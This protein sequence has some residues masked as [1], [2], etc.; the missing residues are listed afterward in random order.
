MEVTIGL[1]LIAGFVSFISPCVLPLVPAYIGYM[2]GRL[3]NQAAA[4]FRSGQSG[5]PK[6]LLQ[7]LTVFFHA[8]AFVAGFSL[9]FVSIGL[10]STAFVQQIGGI[11]IRLLTD[12]IGRLGGL[13][14]MVFGLHFM[15]IL[16]SIFRRLRANEGL[17]EQA[18]TPFMLGLGL[19]AIL[20]W[21]F[22]GHVDV[23]N[24][25]LWRSAPII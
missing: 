21:G 12:L 16:P 19:S 6:N 13:L 17:L 4:D 24:S 18:A 22:S 5:E 9:V 15:D 8:L 11:N 14:I 2:G 1:A 3:T 10:L 23:W 7:R 25:P 20:L